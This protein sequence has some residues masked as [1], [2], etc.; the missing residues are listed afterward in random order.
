MYGQFV[1]DSSV[2]LA[3]IFTNS[4]Y[5]NRI[6]KIQNN[7]Q[8]LQ[9]P[10]KITPFVY[11]ECGKKIRYI[12]NY[13][14][15]TVRNLN[16]RVLYEKDPT[17]QNANLQ[18]TELDE[19]IFMGYF[20]RAAASLS[21]RGSETEK[22]ALEYIETWIIDT[23]E[24][25]LT[26]VSSISARDFFRKCTIEATNMYSNRSSSLGSQ[27]A[28]LVNVAATPIDIANLT[29]RLTTI[30]NQDDVKV[31]AEAIKYRKNQN[32]VV[33]V[34][35]DYREIVRNG[36]FIERITGLRIADPVY[37]LVSLRTLPT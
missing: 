5:K 27:N 4:R 9:I 20:S 25:Q 8:K 10:Y 11:T 16:R 18:L 28:H 17:N 12:G 23:L 2:I 32:K 7:C 3:Q 13:V 35:L 30:G 24:N 14:A 21:A 37:A 26:G 1:Y 36:A 22:E 29:T 33:F 19:P 34:S 6:R 31:L 15:E